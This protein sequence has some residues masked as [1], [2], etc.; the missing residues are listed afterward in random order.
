MDVAP[1]CYKWDWMDWISQGG[2]KYRAAFYGA[3]ECS[4]LNTACGCWRQMLVL[5]VQRFQRRDTIVS[6]AQTE[7]LFNQ[8]LMT[9][10]SV[11]L[12]PHPP[13][14]KPP[15][16]SLILSHWQTHVKS[17]TEADPLS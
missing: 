2:V 4:G 7:A 16:D 10:N 17:P 13:T 11:G 8:P 3:N 5:S 9:V 1:E 12:L 14:S 15:S 6:A